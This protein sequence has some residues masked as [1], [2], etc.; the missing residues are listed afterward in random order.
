ML[1]E[2]NI[3]LSCEAENSKP[4]RWSGDDKFYSRFLSGAPKIPS[5]YEGFQVN[6]LESLYNES[7]AVYRRI[8]EE[9]LENST[10]FQDLGKK[11]KAAEKRKHESAN[12]MRKYE[13][14]AD[15]V[16]SLYNE[17][18]ERVSEPRKNSLIPPPPKK[19]V[20]A[21]QICFSCLPRPQVGTMRN[22]FDNA[23]EYLERLKRQ[24]QKCK[25]RSMDPS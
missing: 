4:W 14:M 17:R 25:G 23:K 10:K 3:K 5:T 6:E 16:R 15:Q 2:M 12:A 7:Y 20:L 8:H 19:K 24:V 1:G 13:K 22:A 11:L 18:A 9:L 21:M